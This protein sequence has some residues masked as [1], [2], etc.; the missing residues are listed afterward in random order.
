MQV[1]GTLPD[2]ITR[3]DLLAALTETHERTITPA[4]FGGR[5]VLI[6]ELTARQRTQA[7][8]AANREN[9]D[10]PDNTLY[11]AMLIQMSVVD[12]ESG[13]AAD[14]RTRTPLLTIDDIL[15]IADGRHDL[16][17][18]LT[19]AIVDL[20]QAAPRHLFRRDPAPDGAQRD[21]GKGAAAGGG[22]DHDA[23]DQGS[24]GADE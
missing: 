7:T 21:A 19:N 15:N 10:E 13:D 24:G 8:E 14:P 11:R 18:E 1:E 5:S 6:R 22:R 12:P 23:P 17:I 16:I 9:P 2:Y 3:A 4:L 20:S